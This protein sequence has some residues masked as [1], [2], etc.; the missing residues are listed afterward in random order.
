MTDCCVSPAKSASVAALDLPRPIWR[1]THRRR[2]GSA[3]SGGH[4][5]LERLAAAPRRRDLLGEDE[6]VLDRH[7]RA[8]PDVRRGRV[9][10]VADEH[11]P[12][13]VPRRL[14]EQ[15]LH[16]AQHDV[17]VASTCASRMP[18]SP[19]NSAR[20]SR[21]VA[22]S[23]SSGTRSSPGGGSSMSRRY[24][25]SGAS[26]TQPALPLRAANMPARRPAAGRGT[27]TRQ[28]TWPVYSGRCPPKTSARTLE[29][30]PSAPTTRS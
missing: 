20:R 4:E 28:Q 11:D 17:L 14:D 2:T 10:G 8:L 15:R 25:R 29:W 18:T 13:A 19:P 9:R 6:R 1:E 16:G 26:G 21:M 12:V 5:P 27:F 7:R 24:A 3:R 22:A 23:R 30:M